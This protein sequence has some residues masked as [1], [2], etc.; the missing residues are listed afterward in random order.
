MVAYN[1]S[2]RSPATHTATVP[3]QPA[4]LA[5]HPGPTAGTLILTWKDM[6]ANETGFEIY[7]KPDGCSSTS[8]WAKVATV[9]ANKTAW[10]DT[11][12]TSGS[13]HA[14]KI[15]SFTKTGSIVPAFGYS[16]FSGCTSVAA[17]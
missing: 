2:G 4:G 17:P 13:I 11:G 9:G 3:F 5:V 8:T 12:R 7:R 10:T 1:A 15:R 16:T 6:S 14:Y